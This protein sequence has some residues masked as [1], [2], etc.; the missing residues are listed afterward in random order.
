MK[1]NNEEHRPVILNCMQSIV[2]GAFAYLVF[3]IAI[4][5]VIPS[6]MSGP[7]EVRALTVIVTGEDEYGDMILDYQGDRDIQ[8]SIWDKPAIMRDLKKYGMVRL[9][10][11]LD[12]KGRGRNSSWQVIKVK[13]KAKPVRVVPVWMI[14]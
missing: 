7:M 2:W 11:E 14:V 8:I 13:K 1:T 5:L 4:H 9:S 12:W 6:A 10:E 3:H